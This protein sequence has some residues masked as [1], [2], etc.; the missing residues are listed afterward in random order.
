MRQS[1][2]AKAWQSLQCIQAAGQREATILS[3]LHQADDRDMMNE[4]KPS[5]ESLARQ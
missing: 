3:Q 5:R 4:L 2:K 1:R